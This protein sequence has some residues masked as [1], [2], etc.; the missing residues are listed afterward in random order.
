[1]ILCTTL[2]RSTF[3]DVITCSPLKVNWRYER[4]CHHLQGRRINQAKTVWKQVA[5]RDHALILF[6]FAWFILL[7]WRWR[8]YVP[9]KCFLAFNGLLD[10]ISLKTDLFI[11]KAARTSNPACNELFVMMCLLLTTG[12]T[13]KSFVWMQCVCQKGTAP[14]SL[15][16]FIHYFFRQTKRDC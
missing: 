9:P 7:P 14:C 16:Q 2:S 1:M 11:N 5:N 8:R 12:L 3:S 15:P 10:V 4:C 13:V 6:F